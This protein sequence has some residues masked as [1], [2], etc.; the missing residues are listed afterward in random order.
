[1]T[2]S[3][4]TFVR[5]LVVAPLRLQLLQGRLRLFPIAAG[6]AEV[7]R[8]PPRTSASLRSVIVWMR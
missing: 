1:M 5:E 7:G 6:R 4:T 2:E 3:C 8:W